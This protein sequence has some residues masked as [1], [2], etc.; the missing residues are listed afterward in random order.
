MADALTKLKNKEIK[1]DELAELVQRDRDLLPMTLKG[2]SSP[3]AHV[4]YPCAKAL[5]MLS[6]DKPEWLIPHFDFFVDLLSSE[7]RILKWNAINTLANL[8]KVDVE[9]QVD[10]IFHHAPGTLAAGSGVYE[11]VL[12]RRRRQVGAAPGASR[13]GLRY[14]RNASAGP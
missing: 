13:G 11:S 1:G 9:D 14:G 2:I 6:E 7:K 8:C 10:A 3:I 12:P 4:R 5:T